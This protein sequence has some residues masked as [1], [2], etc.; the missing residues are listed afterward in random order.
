MVIVGLSIF[1]VGLEKG[2]FP[3]GT[4][5]ANQLS[6]IEFL[7]GGQI[8]AN[9]ALNLQIA[10]SLY[11]WV[12]IFSF[13]IHSIW[14]T[15]TNINRSAPSIGSDNFDFGDTYGK[16]LAFSFKKKLLFY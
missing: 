10:P 7:S 8:K 11:L 13:M 4:Q 16:F 14:Y 5:M 15:A 6:D 2:I 9:E 3:I 1:L 12:Y